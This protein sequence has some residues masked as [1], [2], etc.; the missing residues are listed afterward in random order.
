MQGLLYEKNTLILIKIT[1]KVTFSKCWIF[2]IYE[3]FVVFGN[4]GP[5]KNQSV[6][7]VCFKLHINVFILIALNKI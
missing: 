2:F 1:L 4:H 7:I 3:I 6:F 5:K